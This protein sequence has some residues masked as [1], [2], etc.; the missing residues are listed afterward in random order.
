MKRQIPAIIAA[1]LITGFMTLAMS[2]VGVNALF[3]QNSVPVS[4]STSAAANS[5]Q[6]Q[7]A[8]LQD[9]VKQYQ[10]RETQYQQREQQYQQREQQD[11]Q[12]I[13]QVTAQ[14]QQLLFDLQS[15]G[16]IEVQSDGQIIVTGRP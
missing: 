14:M 8:Q 2:I 1:L 15:R 13:A 12:Q 9:L 5:Q 10:A 6:A 4:N 16:L 11:Q 3:N 7:I